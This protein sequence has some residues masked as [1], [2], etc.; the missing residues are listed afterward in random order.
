MP[1][2]KHKRKATAHAKTKTT[3]S[4][5]LIASHAKM[6]TY[7]GL[8]LMAI[9]IYLFAF[10]SQRNAMFGLAMLSL[11]SGVALTFFAKISATTK[12]KN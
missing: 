10:E 2:N 12:S 8:F 6:F 11:I 4:V 5:G 7:I 1:T 9:S 3:Q